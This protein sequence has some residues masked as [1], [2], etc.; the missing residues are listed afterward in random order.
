MS[1]GGV[2]IV[3]FRIAANTMARNKRRQ[4]QLFNVWSRRQEKKADF[5]PLM[6]QSKISLKKPSL[7]DCGMATD[8]LVEN[9]F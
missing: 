2:K 5:A 9:D 4:I 1:D 3:T 6:F 7:T 8:V